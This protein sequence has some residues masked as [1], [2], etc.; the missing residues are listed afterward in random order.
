[1]YATIADIKKLVTILEGIGI[2]LNVKCQ[3]RK[4]GYIIKNLMY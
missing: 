3:Q 1:M 4:N 2:A